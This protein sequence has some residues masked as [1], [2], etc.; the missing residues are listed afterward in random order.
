MSTGHRP[1]LDLLP[2]EA[3]RRERLYQT[4]K[5]G[6]HNQTHHYVEWLAI[7]A[8]EFGEVA[9]ETNA[10]IWDKKSRDEVWEHLRSELIQ[11]AAVAVAWIQQ[12]DRER[13]S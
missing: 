9:T 10:I 13:K 12:I 7:L 8:E 3:I 11:V 2:Y 5:W 1:Y 4:N 6:E